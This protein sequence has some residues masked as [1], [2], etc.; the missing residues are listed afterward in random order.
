LETKNKKWNTYTPCNEYNANHDNKKTNKAKHCQLPN[1]QANQALPNMLFQT[2][3][4]PLQQG[5]SKKVFVCSSH[6]CGK[7]N[8]AQDGNESYENNDK[9]K[10]EEPVKRFQR[11]GK[12]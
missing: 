6:R 9:A 8:A 3:C 7:D 1:Q 4:F 5:G 12:A 2:C 11:F 10:E